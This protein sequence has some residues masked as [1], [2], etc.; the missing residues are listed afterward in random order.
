MSPSLRRKLTLQLTPL[1]DLLLI[2]L[3][4]QYM[5]MQRLTAQAEARSRQQ[6]A[7][8][9]EE[10]SATRD[11]LLQEEA[12]LMH[13]AAEAKEERRIVGELAAELFRVPPELA[14]AALQPQADTVL[15]PEEV[16]K[17]REE[18]SRFGQMQADELVRHLLTYNELRK[19][20]DIWDVH[21]G[22]SGV[23]TFETGERTLRF[24]ADTPAQFAD[25]LFD[26][27]KT[28]V[29]PKGLVVIL[30][31]WGN[32]RA[33]WREAALQGIPVAAMRMRDDSGGRTRFEYAVLGYRPE[34]SANP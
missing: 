16:E 3:F 2:V 33:L 27:Y 31:S 25:H 13:L 15:S 24:R 21:I 23:I 28:L 26:H 6:V 20:A 7:S 29:Q 5:E 34:G 19:R 11:E 9:E 8:V 10:L 30:L 17:L 32:A 22:E 12:R 1:L 4:A 14:R 18:L